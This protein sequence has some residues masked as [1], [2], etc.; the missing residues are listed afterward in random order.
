[1]RKMRLQ[2]I[3]RLVTTVDLLRHINFD[4]LLHGLNAAGLSAFNRVECRMAALSN[5][6]TGLVLYHDQ[7]GNHLNS[8]GQT[9]DIELEKMNFFK[10][11]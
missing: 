7:Y 8:S 2:D 4:A 9:I 6:L 10:A 3:F 1:M 11:V 5:D